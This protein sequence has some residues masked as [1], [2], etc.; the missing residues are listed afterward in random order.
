MLCHILQEFFFF[1]K[2]KKIYFVSLA[3]LEI[4]RTTLLFQVPFWKEMQV[5]FK[6]LKGERGSH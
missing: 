4:K 1:F 2:K 5:P 3:F 6:K